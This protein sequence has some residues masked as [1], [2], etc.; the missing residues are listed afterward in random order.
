MSF[1][2]ITISYLNF[3]IENLNFDQSLRKKKAYF[4][5]A[6]TACL[7]LTLVY[8]YFTGL[9]ITETMD[10]E[11]LKAKGSRLLSETNQSALILTLEQ[12]QKSVGF[13]LKLGFEEPENQ[14]VIKRNH[15]VAK[16][17]NALLF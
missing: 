10:L 11:N 1:L 9:I 16:S 2:N 4:K 14:D 5:S 17:V 3:Q 12:A 15:D 13:Y 6:A 8:I 7:L